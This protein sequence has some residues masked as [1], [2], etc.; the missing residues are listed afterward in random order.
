MNGGP[1]VVL[2]DA[3][4][5]VDMEGTVT[6]MSPDSPPGAPAPVVEYTRRHDRPGGA[7]LA[8][9]IAARRRDRDVVLV[10]S[11]GDDEAGQ[12]IM[13]ML[14]GLVEL[15]AIPLH[16]TTPQKIRVRAGSQLL[17]RVDT[18]QGEAGGLPASTRRRVLWALRSASAVLVSDYGQGLAAQPAI[19]RMLTRAAGDVPVV[20]DPHPKGMAPVPRICLATPN[21]SEA[22]RFCPQPAAGRSGSVS[23]AGARAARLTR[24]WAAGGVA[25]TL[26]ARGA[27]LA[28]EDSPPLVAPAP[29]VHA[30]DTCGAGDSFAV[31]AAHAIA[32]GGSLAD[33][34]VAG[35]GAATG[36]VAAGAASGIRFTAV[37]AMPVPAMPVPAAGP[38]HGLTTAQARIQTSKEHTSKERGMADERS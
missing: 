3:V 24:L 31:A 10:T 20:W 9:L 36:F 2:G 23:L 38:P 14:G 27:V 29:R 4:L 7:G 34:V 16:G 18:G 33:A 6:R 19:A 37:P 30:R 22:V 1:L 25:V 17:L 32:D 12:R 21:E 5:D 11:V 26:G 28:M 8:G 13:D 15:I 35:V